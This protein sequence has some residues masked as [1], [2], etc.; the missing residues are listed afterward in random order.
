MV[1]AGYAATSIAA[2]NADRRRKGGSMTGFMRVL[3]SYPR[4][5]RFK[6][7]GLDLRPECM[8]GKPH[9]LKKGT[10]LLEN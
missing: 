4:P 7:R 6:G 8:E 1:N 9:F 5:V 10:S 3:N 2:L